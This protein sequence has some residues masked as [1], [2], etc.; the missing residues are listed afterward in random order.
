MA[1]TTETAPAQGPENP[2][3][4]HERSDASIGPIIKF[5][6]ALAA[7][8]LV[9][10]LVLAWMFVLL[11]DRED[12]VKPKPPPLAPRTP[13]LPPDAK[14]VQE[15]FPEPRLQPAPVADL[16]AVR[17]E[18]EAKLTGYGY[19]PKTKTA[20]IPIERAIEL[21]SDPKTAAEHGI[22]VRSQQDAKKPGA[23]D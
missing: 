10:H 17:A 8:A 19:D 14:A 3:V 6:V 7:V 13:A 1:E 15:T 21:L 11:E 22:R 18:E 12:R 4:R 16:E 5:G 2:D 20:R 9:A 23:A